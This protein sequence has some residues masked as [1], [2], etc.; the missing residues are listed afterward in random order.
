MLKRK[1]FPAVAAIAA[2]GSIL[3]GSAMALAPA[4]APAAAVASAS[5]VK[6]DFLYHG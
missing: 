2:A 4:A 3:A 6:P 1:I 5:S